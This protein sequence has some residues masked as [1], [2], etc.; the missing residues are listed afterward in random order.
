MWRLVSTPR[1]AVQFLLRRGGPGTVEHRGAALSEAARER[2]LSHGLE[3]SELDA[4]DLRE[5]GLRYPEGWR[6]RGNRIYLAD[7]VALVP[8]FVAANSEL[9]QLSGVLVVLGSPIDGLAVLGIHGDGALVF[10]GPECWLPS[11]QV[12]C[13]AD[14]AVVLRRL[15]TCT[16][17]GHV[18]ARNGGAIFADIDQLWSERVYIA[19]DDMHT[20]IDVKSGARLNPFGGR[21]SIGPHV[22]LGRESVITGGARLGANSVIG[23]R[24]LVRAGTYPEGAVLVGTPA[25]VGRTGVTWSRDDLP[26]D[27]Q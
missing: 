25:R 26:G 8:E 15:V 16:F 24:S 9:S 14:S 3:A 4:L 13:G 12:H 20:L 23:M 18:D 17:A 1:R 19:T 11:T 21:I 27:A 6:E 5:A 2:L 10:I 7:G 22:W